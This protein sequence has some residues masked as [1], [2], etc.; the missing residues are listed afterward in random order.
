[1]SRKVKRSISLDGDVLELFELLGVPHGQISQFVNDLLKNV[2]YELKRR[3]K[4]CE[5]LRFYLKHPYAYLFDN[6]RYAVLDG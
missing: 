6:L 5:K 2:L 4:E 3:E 1:M